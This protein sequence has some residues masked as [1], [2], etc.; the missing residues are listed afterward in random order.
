MTRE[1]VRVFWRSR[2]RRNFEIREEYKD[3]YMAKWCALSSCILMR[4]TVWKTKKE[5]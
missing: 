1:K 2:Y 3:L 5:K 4:V